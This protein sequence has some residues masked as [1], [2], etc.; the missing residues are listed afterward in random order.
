[1]ALIGA[2]WTASAQAAP[3]LRLLETAI[4]IDIAP[5]SDGAA[6][7]VGAYNAGDG[8]LNLQVSSS[9]A[10]ATPTLGSSQ[11]CIQAGICI[12]IQIALHTSGLAKGTY[13]AFIAVSDPNAIDAPQNI[14]VVANIGGQVPDQ[15]QFYLPPGGTASDTV[16][17]QTIASVT[18][19]GAT[20]LSLSG[21]GMGTFG[22]RFNTPIN[23]NASAA[24][25]L[26]VGDYDATLTISG[27][28]FLPDNKTVPVTM[29]LT[30]LPIMQPSQ[31]S[32]L[33]RVAQG[34]KLSSTVTF[35]N[36]GQ[37]AFV[38]SGAVTSTVAGGNWLSASVLNANTVVI[39]SDAGGLAT[40]TYDGKVSVTG[41]CASGASAA[42]PCFAANSPLAIP[43]EMV[44][45]PA[46]PPVASYGGVVNN[47]SFDANGGLAL[48]DIAAVFGEQFTSGEAMAA[49]SVPLSATLDGLSVSVNGQPVPLYFVSYG[50]INF[51]VPYEAQTGDALLQVGRNGVPGNT[52]SM[53][54]APVSPRI[55]TG[56]NNYGLIVKQ[57]GSLALPGSPAKVGDPVT[58]YAI[59]LGVTSPAVASGSGSPTA[60]ALA[61]VAA[62]VQACFGTVCVSPDFAGLTPGFVGLYQVN[63]TVPAGVATG[64]HVP[65][66]LKMATA[67]SNLV[68]MSLQ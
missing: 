66:S 50:Q 43:V 33:L 1:M 38:V 63:V 11:E 28:T 5:G 58:I 3:K 62:P 18:T 61:V 32:V 42:Q 68:W 49:S 29:H 20:W 9:A 40:G 41:T 44:V 15:L 67:A 47:A 65:V 23:V 52:I 55:L 13:T 46:G 4:T 21:G 57:D 7:T 6:Q 59:G 19:S 16:M 39:T 37:S 36:T 10:W 30:T 22:F 51:Q 17:T 53:T 24:A 60:P 45:V 14:V 27:S 12:P 25:G 34:L 64:D 2:I 8:T 35:A 54:I 48:G 26:G 56:V 31:P